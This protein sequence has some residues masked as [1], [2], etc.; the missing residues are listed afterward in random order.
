MK[1]I[2]VALI[3]LISLFSKTDAPTGGYQPG[4]VAADF[5]LKNVDGKT[6][7]LSDF[8]NVKGYIVVFTCNH[9]PFAVAYE[10]RIIELNNKYGKM[11]YQLVAI[12]PNDPAQVPDDNLA[13]MKVR[14]ASKG[15]K[16]PYL[17]DEG[18]KVYP[19]FGAT[20]TPHAFLLDKNRVVKYVGAIDDSA[21]DASAVKTKYLENAIAALEAGQAINPSVTKAVGCGIKGPKLN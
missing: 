20:K 19:A 15:F 9:C 10:D 4:D 3:S 5:K 18:Q 14:A 21:M 13:N 1:L 11:G 17:M 12:Q 6:V 8:K 16:F 2:S 7:S